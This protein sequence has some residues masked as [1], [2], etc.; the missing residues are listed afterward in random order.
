VLFRSVRRYAAQISALCVL[1]AIVVAIRLSGADS[2]LT[3]ENLRKHKELLEQFI[4]ARYTLSV[5]V[6]M[7]VYL[8]SVAFSVPGATV[9]TLAGGFL[10]HLFPGVVYVVA[11]ATLGATFAFLLSRYILGNTIQNKYGA[12]LQRFNREVDENGHLYLL[13]VRFIP[14]FPFFLINILSGLTKVPFWTYVW[15]TSVG[16]LPGSIVYTFAG[17]QLGT[18]NSIGDL[19]GGRIL[20]AFLLLAALTLIP[21]MLKKIRAKSH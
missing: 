10:F 8:V 5:L 15:T 17:S 1:I 6:Y 9:L 20:I 11:G 4:S 14:V 13:T 7:L 18:I 19:F 21:L 16:I 12:Q 2:Y 3:V